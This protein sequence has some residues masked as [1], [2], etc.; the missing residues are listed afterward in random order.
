MACKG[1]ALEYTAITLTATAIAATKITAKSPIAFVFTETTLEATTTKAKTP[2][3]RHSLWTMNTHNLSLFKK[4]RFCQIFVKVALFLVQKC[5]CEEVEGGGVCPYCLWWL[6]AQNQTILSM[7]I[8]GL[9][10][11]AVRVKTTAFCLFQLPAWVWGTWW[12]PGSPCPPGWRRAGRCPIG[13][14]YTHSQELRYTIP[15]P[16]AMC[17]SRYSSQWTHVKTCFLLLHILS[18]K[19]IYKIVASVK[20]QFFNPHHDLFMTTFFP[21]RVKNLVYWKYGWIRAEHLCTSLWSKCRKTGMVAVARKNG[22][23]PNFAWKYKF[24]KNV[25]LHLLI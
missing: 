21:F 5:R 11:C 19:Q 24:N 13:S 3:A 1:K 22:A 15:V 16:R 23:E 17:T 2:T 20:L 12:T 25:I 18:Y 8:L 7:K 4:W 6:K 10:G 9:A 14:L